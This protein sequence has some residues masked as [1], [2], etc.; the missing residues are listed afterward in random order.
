L[1]LVIFALLAGA[2]VSGC[3][4]GARG[5]EPERIVTRWKSENAGTIG[6]S[7]FGLVIEK[8]GDKVNGRFLEL[9]GRDGFDILESYPPGRY[10]PLT[11]EMTLPLGRIAGGSLDDY[12]KSGMPYLKVEVVISRDRLVGQ[13]CMPGSEPTPYTFVRYE[14]PLASVR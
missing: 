11:R 12:L 8:Q 14:P 6:G 10:D 1:A 7:V 4:R 13:Y 9:K 5:R 2:I 3:D